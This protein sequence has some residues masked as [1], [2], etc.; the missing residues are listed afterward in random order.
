MRQAHYVISKTTHQPN[1]R[2]THLLALLREAGPDGDYLIRCEQGRSWLAGSRGPGVFAR[3]PH[4]A[5]LYA[6]EPL[7][8][9]CVAVASALSEAYVT[10][11]STLR[12]ASGLRCRKPLYEKCDC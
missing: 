11:P 6:V 2:M 9:S 3:T 8:V 7:H 10:L 12:L 1:E 5:R 4:R